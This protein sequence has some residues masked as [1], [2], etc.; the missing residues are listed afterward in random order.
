MNLLRILIVEPENNKNVKYV[1]TFSHAVSF[2][3]DMLNK[4]K[5]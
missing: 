4:K 1:S 5:L 2:V 3:L